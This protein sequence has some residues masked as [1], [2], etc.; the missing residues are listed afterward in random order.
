[1]S[2]ISLTNYKPAAT[3]SIKEINF[4]KNET[5]TVKKEFKTL[6]LK[7]QNSAFSLHQKRLIQNGILNNLKIKISRM[8]TPLNKVKASEIISPKSNFCL[9][10]VNLNKN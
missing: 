9:G 8:E 4:T 10:P 7:L 5:V 2:A 1:L 3:V 6:K